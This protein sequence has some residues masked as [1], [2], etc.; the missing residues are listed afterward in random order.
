MKTPAP[1]IVVVQIRPGIAGH[2]GLLVAAPRAHGP[3]EELL[4]HAEPK[5]LPH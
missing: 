1:S 2:V 4:M 3:R 5:P